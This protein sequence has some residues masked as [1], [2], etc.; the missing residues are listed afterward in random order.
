M[1]HGEAHTKGNTLFCDTYIL[2]FN[3]NRNVAA[4][5][6]CKNSKLLL[7]FTDFLKST[8]VSFED[9]RNNFTIITDFELEASVVKLA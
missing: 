5:S 8:V 3:H 9:T 6:V 4:L 1:L 7:V 2:S